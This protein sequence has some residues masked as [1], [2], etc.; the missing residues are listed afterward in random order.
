M[1]TTHQVQVLTANGYLWRQFDDKFKALRKV[2]ATIK[3]KR[4]PSM[5]IIRS[6][7]ESLF[8]ATIESWKVRWMAI[9]YLPSIGIFLA[10]EASGL[11]YVDL[12]LCQ[13]IDSC[14]CFSHHAIIVFMC[15][16]KA[17]DSEDVE[18]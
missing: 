12:W 4:P 11:L 13:R 10:F 16:L 9:R 7:S 1:S 18:L 2:L 3:F 5:G 6:M 14:C 8:P 15:L 17:F